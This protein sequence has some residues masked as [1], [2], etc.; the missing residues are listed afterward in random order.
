MVELDT[1]VAPR[2]AP[3]GLTTVL[4]LNG[5]D[6]DYTTAA[7][8]LSEREVRLVRL[9]RLDELLGQLEKAE[10]ALCVIDLTTGLDSAKSLRAVRNRFPQALV[11][12]L[13]DPRRPEGPLEAFQRGVFDVLSVPVST[14]DFSSV[15]RNVDEFLALA[16]PTSD[17][18]PAAA[19]TAGLVLESES[20]RRLMELVQRVGAARC[21]VMIAGDF[22]T[23]R[24][25][26]ARLLHAS[27]AHSAGPFIKIDCN[28]GSSSEP[29]DLP[30][31]ADLPKHN[32]ALLGGG[33]VEGLLS[34][35]ASG[36]LFIEHIEDM[37]SRIQGRLA[38]LLK[39][40]ADT[41]TAPTTR[42][43]VS[44]QPD[45]PDLVQNGKVRAELYQKLALVRIDVPPLRERR[46]DVPVLARQIL[47]ELCRTR[48]YPRKTLTRSAMT[49]LGALPWPG[50][51]PELRGLIERLAVMLP[52]G[53]IRLEDL[54]SHVSLS[55]SEQQSTQQATTLRE[56]RERFERDYIAATLRKH[57]GR[58]AETAQALGIQRTNLYRKVRALKL[59]RTGT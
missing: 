18:L 26:V 29:P 12:G 48:G 54:L 20:M 56:A 35:A 59:S 32:D 7:Q 45:F 53:V 13:V 36:T 57:R 33:D 25:T 17:G 21:H 23:G 39:E 58:M 49:L 5:A 10:P 42:V 41:Q 3:T 6:D 47:S 40:A 22:G 55:G 19:E 38:R 1:D 2:E 8:V 52:G 34:K 31:L 30:E 43:M 4:W 50:N 11:V 15:V 16:D 37:S 27:S 46:D 14:Q 24:E 51:L 9:E 44:V 28:G